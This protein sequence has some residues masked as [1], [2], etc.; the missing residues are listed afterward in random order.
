MQEVGKGKRERRG[1][2]TKYNEGIILVYPYYG[3][4]AAGINK[5]GEIPGDN[6]GIIDIIIAVRVLRYG[7]EGSGSIPEQ[8]HSGFMITLCLVTKKTDTCN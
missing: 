7:K 6:R 5:R 3:G 2:Y 1:K 4:G 8:E